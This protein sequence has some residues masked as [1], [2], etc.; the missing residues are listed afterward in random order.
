M[1]GIREV[2][3]LV[4][5]GWNSYTDIRERKISL[6]SV[7]ILGAAG[8]GL[9]VTE[10]V[11]PWRLVVGLLPGMVMM[12]ISWLTGGALGMGDGILMLGIGSCLSVRRRWV[13]FLQDFFSLLWGLG[14][15]CSL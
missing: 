12:G 13:L 2:F 10:W 3:V 6:V 9:A 8:V 5:L 7:A 11:S 1:D 15:T 4:V 14:L